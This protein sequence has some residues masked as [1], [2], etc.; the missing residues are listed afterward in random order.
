MSQHITK[1]FST[2][3]FVS[4]L[5]IRDSLLVSNSISRCPTFQLRADLRVVH[6]ISTLSR[7]SAH[8]TILFLPRDATQS[9]VLLRQVVC[10]SV[11]WRYRDYISCNYSKI[12]SCVRRLQTPT[13][14]RIY[15]KG[16]PRNFGRNRGELSKE[17]LWARFFAFSGVTW[18]KT[19]FANYRRDVGLLSALDYCMRMPRYIMLHFTYLLTF[20]VQKF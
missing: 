1:F 15:S 7:I 9:A 14:S 4:P 2:Q 13:T 16:T 6:L 12:I 10:L 5:S 11:T 17:W 18:K 8:S 19:L 3:N 20:C